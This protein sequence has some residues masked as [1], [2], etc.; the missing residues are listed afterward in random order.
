MTRND[1]IENITEWW[2]LLDFCS[3][4]GCSI[5]E[6]IY[7]DDDLDNMIDE[8]IANAVND[9]MGWGEIRDRLCDIDCS[10]DYY[11]SEGYMVYEGLNDDD[12]ERYK[13]DVLNWMDDYDRW[14]EEDDDFYD[15]EE[16]PIFDE[17]D[18]SENDDDFQEPEEDF[19][20]TELVSMCILDVT[21]QQSEDAKK[22]A[23][24]QAEIDRALAEL[25]PLF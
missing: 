17:S 11:V 15:N 7:H 4:E 21:I 23:N 25:L 2:Q 20:V 13:N 1:F 24:E 9:G 19:S 22:K 18:E 10:Y 14:D 16:D 12:F 6:G 8:D 3:D 5:C